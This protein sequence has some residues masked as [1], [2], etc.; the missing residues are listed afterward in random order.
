MSR[1]LNDRT[2]AQEC[3]GRAHSLRAVGLQAVLL[4]V[5][6]RMPQ[7][8]LD[9]V[10]G[11]GVN[12]DAQGLVVTL[13]RPDL[14]HRSPDVPACVHFWRGG[15]PGGEWDSPVRGLKAM[16]ALSCTA[17]PPRPSRPP[18]FNLHTTN[19]PGR[20]CRPRETPG[21]P[22]P[23]SVSRTTVLTWSAFSA[24]T[25]TNHGSAAS[26]PNRGSICSMRDCHRC[27]A[28][29]L[30]STAAASCAGGER[31]RFPS[32]EQSSGRVGASCARGHG[33][34]S[35]GKANKHQAVSGLAMGPREFPA[36]GPRHPAH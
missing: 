17:V 7:H 24:S 27:A 10:A 20:G 12:S 5:L 9:G 16:H 13:P 2:P 11:P 33:L 19:Q 4:V 23:S 8:G 28:A 25:L 29:S 34:A 15:G 22:S 14:V 32:T 3:P 36:P 18:F 6:Q 30:L 1:A 35:W 26:A 21:A 31:I